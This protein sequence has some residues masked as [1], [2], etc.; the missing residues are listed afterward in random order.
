MPFPIFWARIAL[1]EFVSNMTACDTL[2]FPFTKATHS[3]VSVFRY[4][5]A[6]AAGLQVCVIVPARNEADNLTQTLSALYRQQDAYGLPL[7]KG[8][9]EVLLLINNCTDDSVAVARRFQQQHPDFALYIAEVYL[10]KDKANIGT[11]RRMLM[12][13]A[14]RRL[15]QSGNCAKG[16]IASTDGDTVVDERW[17][18]SIVQEIEKG[19][20][21]VGGRILTTRTDSPVRLW[22]LRNVMYRTLLAQ[23]EAIVDPCQH[24]PWPRHFQYFGANLAVTCGVYEQAGRLPEVPFLED[25]AFYEALKM[26]DARIRKS[27]TVKAYTSDRQQGR[28]EIGFSEQLK[29]WNKQLAKKELQVTEPVVPQVLKWNIRK[30]LR[31]VYKQFQTTGTCNKKEVAALCRPLQIPFDWM[32]SKM[33]S[34]NY[35]G[36]LWQA[37]EKRL[38]ANKWNEQWLPQSI[39]EAIAELRLFVSQ[40]G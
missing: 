17:V 4:A 11:V 30:A 1:R 38:I 28:V 26:I 19:A 9:Y 21:A 39:T 33:G 27:N 18:C 15:K 10:P 7:S 24:D 40:K 20:D 6:P 29:T 35:F 2:T 23:A 14:C 8:I 31:K 25:H 16:I 13:E 37:V 22:H 32:M 3:P 12:D 34:S 5:A 36:A